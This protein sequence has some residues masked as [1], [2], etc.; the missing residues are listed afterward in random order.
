MEKERCEVDKCYK[1]DLEKIYKTVEDI[2][3]D[4]Q[5]VEE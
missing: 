2:D 1:W 5:K 3:K 4:K